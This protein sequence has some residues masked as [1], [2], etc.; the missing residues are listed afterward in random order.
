M[1]PPA[2]QSGRKKLEPGEKDGEI[3]AVRSKH[4]MAPV[5]T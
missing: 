5:C 3:R 4:Q 2:F 1:P